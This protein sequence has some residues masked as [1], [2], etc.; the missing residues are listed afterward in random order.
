MKKAG[1]KTGAN[2]H[3]GYYV[4][5]KFMDQSKHPGRAPK[6]KSAKEREKRCWANTKRG[7]KKK[8]ITINRRMKKN[9]QS[10]RGGRRKAGRGLCRRRRRRKEE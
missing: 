5:E 2:E 1:K 8:A 7:L 6:E 10:G 9:N 3:F 4:K